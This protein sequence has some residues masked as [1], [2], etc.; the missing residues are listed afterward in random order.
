MRQLVQ[1]KENCEFKSVKLHRKIDL[2]S[3][4]A[5]V[6][7]LVN[8]INIII[9][10]CLSI[11]KLANEKSKKFGCLDQFGFRVWLQ[12]GLGIGV[13]IGLDLI[14]LD[15]LINKYQTFYSKG[16]IFVNWIT[17]TRKSGDHFC[18]TYKL[19]ASYICTLYSRHSHLQGHI[20]PGG[21]F[22]GFSGHSNSIYNKIPLLKKE[23]LPL[24]PWPWGYNNY[25]DVYFQSSMEDMT[26]VCCKPYGCNLQDTFRLIGSAITMTSWFGISCEWC[27]LMAQW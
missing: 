8:R 1:E 24:F 25:T 6:E 3:Y 7:G 14:H 16:M 2:V 26:L 5:R 20:F 15:L 13:E 12:L 21:L 22:A 17:M 27:G 4:P 11:C 18:M 9:T 19:H 23:N 10:H